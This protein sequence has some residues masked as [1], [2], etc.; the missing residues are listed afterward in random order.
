MLTFVFRN[1]TKL[2][3]PHKRDMLL[4]E[5][6]LEGRHSLSLKPSVPCADQA[7]Q[8]ADINKDGVI[9]EEE[10]KQWMGKHGVASIDSSS[11]RGEGHTEGHT[12]D[13]KPPSF[14]QLCK[15]GVRSGLPFLGF[16]ICD[17]GLMLG[18]SLV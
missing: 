15:L 16:G 18:E 4:V 7:F 6:S 9:T 14:S 17:N 8:A 10:F 3:P 13:T 5:G 2:L 12:E 1:L 11:L